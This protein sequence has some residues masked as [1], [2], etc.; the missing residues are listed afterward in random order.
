MDEIKAC[1][2]LIKA[3]NTTGNRYF[4]ELNGVAPEVLLKIMMI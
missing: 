4:P 3:N 2:K 1:F